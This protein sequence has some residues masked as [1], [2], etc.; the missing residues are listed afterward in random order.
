LRV[1]VDS[2]GWLSVLIRTDRYHQ[3]GSH[4]YQQI[5][6]QRA[7]LLTSDFVLDEVITRLRYDVGHATA[8]QFIYLARQAAEQQVLQVLRV[9][10]EIWREAEDLFL[11]YADVKLSFT[12]CTSFA[13]I[14]RYPVDAVF[15]YDR[16][17]AMLGYALSPAVDPSG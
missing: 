4:Y 17:F 10:E 9:N 1:F 12:D 3:A 13:L 7:I 2:G 8:A 5:L 16:H 15:G 6:A 11:E 14:R